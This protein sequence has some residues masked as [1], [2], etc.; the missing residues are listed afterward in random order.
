M[1]WTDEQWDAFC[2]LIAGGW[3]GDFADSERAAYRVLLDGVEPQAAILAVRELVL[4]GREFYPRPTASDIAASARG[5]SSTPTF[6][7]MLL[8][9]RRAMKAVDPSERIAAAHPL[10]A[11]FVDRQGWDRLRTL[12]LDCPDWGEKTRR[13]LREAWDRHVESQDRR[14]V[15]ALASGRGDLKQLDPLASLQLGSGS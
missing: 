11:S 8:L 5:D 1:T 4:S 12:P 14:Q 9:L 6:D 15:A 2:A 13:E 10:V 7:E 3:G